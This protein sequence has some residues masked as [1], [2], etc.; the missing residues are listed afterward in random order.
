[1]LIAAL[2]TI[3]KVWNKLNA[4][5]QI[6]IDKNLLYKN[7]SYLYKSLSIYQWIKMRW[8]G[9]R[10]THTHTHTH[11]GITLSHNRKESFA[12]CSKTDG[13]GGHYAK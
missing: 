9:Y 2:F 1:M 3:A 11:N 6:K 13:L 12:T 5:Q 7:T 8:Y 4:H 10:H